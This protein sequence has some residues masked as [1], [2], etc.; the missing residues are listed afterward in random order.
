MRSFPIIPIWLM[1]I[2][3]LLLIGYILF[4]KRRSI[5]QILIV[6][7]LFLINLRF[8]TPT[9]NVKVLSNNLDILFVVDSTISM[10]AEDYDG[11]KTRL[12]GV[13][14]DCDYII[15]EL[16]G[17]RYSLITFNN[18]AKVITPFTRDANITIEAI[19]VI[20][21]VEKLYAKGSSLNTPLE[22]MISSLKSSK[23]KGDRIR[24]LFF[25][26]DGEITD[27]SSLKSYKEI[28]KYVTDG[29]VLGYGTSKGGNM[30]VYDY[31]DE[32]YEYIMDY[33]GYNYGKAVS[34]IDEDNLKKIAKD[35]GID[36]IHMTD[37]N[38]LDKKIAQIK[39]LM[40]TELESTNRESYDDLYY[41]LIIPLLI[42]IAIE[43][44][45]LRRSSL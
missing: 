1:T 36:Y 17:A 43:L 11:N 32:D 14:K 2:I 3:C 15:K 34:K 30:K 44:R 25:I 40:D 9:G 18:N 35:A 37:K 38:K 22:T 12:E 23:K 39:K 45:K 26:S 8:M 19:G 24:I 21:P 27:N 33:S 5:N 13:K 31:L 29:A 10:N 41:Y 7:L 28:K 16:N 6:I 42:L 20:K 4:N